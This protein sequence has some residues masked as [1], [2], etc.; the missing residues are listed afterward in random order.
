MLQ[1]VNPPNAAFP[2]ISQA[3]TPPA[4]AVVP[5]EA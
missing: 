2:G 4:R 5:D 3:T 1:A